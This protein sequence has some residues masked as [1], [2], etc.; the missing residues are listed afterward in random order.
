[1][2]NAGN[3]LQIEDFLHLLDQQGE[4][5]LVDPEGEILDR[6]RH[7]SFPFRASSAAH[8]THRRQAALEPRVRLVLA[9]VQSSA[10]PAPTAARG[11]CGAAFAAGGATAAFMVAILLLSL[12]TAHAIDGA[13]SK[14]KS[15]IA[16]M[17]AAVAPPAAK[18]A[19]H[20][21]KPPPAARASRST[22]TRA[23]TRRT[24]TLSAPDED[25]SQGFLTTPEW[26]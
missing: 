24:R 18:A 4:A 23:R 14:L 10:K 9:R 12:E 26:E 13:V 3:R 8:P 6:L 11:L 22:C 21:P 20:K 25:V 1:M 15:K 2:R 17:K 7:V 19:A 5:L 16:T